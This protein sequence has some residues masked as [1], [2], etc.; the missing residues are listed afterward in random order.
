MGQNEGFLMQ[1]SKIDSKMIIDSK[2][3]KINFFETTIIIKQICD[4]FILRA[5]SL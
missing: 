2:L 1:N 5:E 3:R 4:I